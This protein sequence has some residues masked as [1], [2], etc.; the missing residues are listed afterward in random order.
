[1]WGVWGV[2]VLAD[3]K[4]MGQGVGEHGDR[5]VHSMEEECG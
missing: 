1:M 4:Y 3:R 2:S 5:A